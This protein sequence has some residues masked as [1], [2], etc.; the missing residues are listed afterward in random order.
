VV[1]PCCNRS[2]PQGRSAD[3]T[4]TSNGDLDALIARL[5]ALENF[6]G[7]VAVGQNGRTVVRQASGLADRSAGIPN[8]PATRFVVASVTQ[9]FTAVAV[10]QLVER[11]QVSLDDS[12]ST[13]VPDFPNKPAAKSTVRQ[14]LTHTAAI[15]GVVTSEE[16]RRAPG[17]FRDLGNY[18]ALV[19]ERPLT[20]EPGHFRYTDGDSVLL[21]VIIERASGQ[22]WDA[23]L[24]DHVF[25]PTAMN[26]TGFDLTPRPR[27]LAVGYTTRAPDGNH[28]SPAAPH[29]NSSILPAK[30]SPG[31]AA[32]S[33]ADDLLRFGDALIEG[34]LLSPATSTL[35]LEGQVPTGDTGP[36]QQYGFGFFDGNFENVRIVNHGGTGPGIDVAF[37]IYPEVGFV[38]VVMSNSDPPAAQRIRDELRKRLSESPRFPGS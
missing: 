22:A 4:E 6:S 18:V 31:S 11:G 19:A 12:L 33:T 27:D 21:G 26:D 1:G 23:Y 5:G 14:L 28:T 32:Y 20:G 17:E 7:V 2:D 35:L 15:G 13:F 30:A 24:R 10:A 3:A 9:T 37:D 8:N 29:D 25:Q 36:R 16:F 38:V 34:R